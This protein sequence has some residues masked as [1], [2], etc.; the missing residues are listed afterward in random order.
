M[1]NMFSP[2][3]NADDF[4]K[5][6]G[7]EEILKQAWHTKMNRIVSNLVNE[8]DNQGN[9]V[10]PRFYNPL[11]TPSGNQVAKK[12]IPWSGYPLIIENWLNLSDASSLAE[13]DQGYR[14]AE[15]LREITYVYEVYKQNGAVID[16]GFN[17]RNYAPSDNIAMYPVTNGSISIQDAFSLKER[18]QDEYLEWHTKKDKT[19]KVVQIS[20]TAEG[21]EYWE[22]I[23]EN[24]PDLLTD[25]YQEYVDE[26]VKTDDLYWQKDIAC[27]VLEIELTTGV[28]TLTSFTIVYKKGAYNQF[29]KW[30]T[31]LGIMHLI[32]RNNSLGAEVRLAADATKRYGARPDLTHNPTRFELV[33]CGIPAGINR[34]S[35]PTISDEVNKLAL[36]DLK[37]TISNPIGLYIGEIQISGIKDPNG[38][39]VNSG[40]IL[41]IER[42]DQDP[43]EPKILRFKLTIPEN[44]EEGLENY[45]LNGF[46]LKYGG[47][48]AKETSIVIYGEAIPSSD[49]NPIVPCSGKACYHPQ[50]PAFIRPIDIN[51][52]CGA[53]DWSRVESPFT[54]AAFNPTPA[55][56]L[57]LVEVNKSRHDLIRNPMTNLT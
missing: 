28:T 31:T 44:S 38:N 34:N 22:T 33:A 11:D 16:Q 14:S 55:S 5:S 17:F 36:S 6:N 19:G 41:T 48:V 2:P 8:K 52:D 9:T 12:T 51:S 20:Y 56:P 21:P 7:K 15:I 43:F 3:A 50:K 35:D 54:V 39:P 45:S 13:H 25:L 4:S 1:A 26:K 37:V 10:Y 49:P 47:P 23:A 18:I 27:P 42:G 40:D 32:Q 57:A 30:N 46:N 29:N 24:D 53:F